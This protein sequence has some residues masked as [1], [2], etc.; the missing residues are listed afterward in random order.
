MP[1]YEPIVPA[2]YT[3]PLLAL[4]RV[5][6]LDTQ[7]EL[8]AAAGIRHAEIANPDAS[9]T[10]PQF[11]RLLRAVSLHTGRDDL[12]FEIGS[13]VTLDLHGALGVALRRCAT[14]DAALRL[15]VRYYHLMTPGF[16]TEYHRHPDR[17]EFVYLPA[18][19]MS[20]ETL[21]ALLEIHATAFHVQFQAILGARLRSYDI[22]VSVD[23]PKH[24]SRY[25]GLH[26]ARFHFGHLGLPQ[27]RV[28]IGA[29]LLNETIMLAPPE[30]IAL[31]RAEQR[32][33]AHCWTDW[34]ILMLREAEG[35]QPSL[36]LLASLLNVSPRTLTRQ[37]EREKQNFREIAKRVRHDRACRLLAD[38]RYPISQIAYRLG[39]TDVANFS[40]AFRAACG[41]SPRQYRLH[42][43]AT[44][45]GPEPKR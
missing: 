41:A 15:A 45:T 9:L 17:G 7:N 18:A 27:V 25:A 11:D 28:V 13:R 32:E 38:P 39:Y 4:V 34:V 43:N 36:Q 24:A 8:L 31:D 21:H 33:R 19:Y 5:E 30:H 22:Y 40:H 10:M 23:E 20:P 12:G 14:V 2:R 42:I 29:S 6:P 37:L 3:A 26:P 44:K 16:R 35:C 1:L